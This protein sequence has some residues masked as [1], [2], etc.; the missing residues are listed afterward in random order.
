ELSD[1]NLTA[2]GHCTEC[3]VP[4][5]GVFDGPKGDWGARRLPVRL[6]SMRL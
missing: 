4:C 6:S 1:W 3:G 2:D 5:A